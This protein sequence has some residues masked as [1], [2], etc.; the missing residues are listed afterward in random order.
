MLRS[1]KDLE[2]YTIA[3]TDG[4]VG[5]V[6][7]FLLDDER[8]TIRYL[9][10]ETGGFLDGR[11]VLVS[12][13]SLR[14]V[15][16]LNRR[17]HL[18]LTVDKIKNSPSVDT[19]KPVSR[20]HERDFYRYYG[21]PSYWEDLGLWG[22]GAYPSLLATGEYSET[23]VERPEDASADVHLRSAKE[24]RGYDIQGSDNAI[25]HFE[26]FIVEDD[27]W[28]LRYLVVDTRNWWFGKKVLVAPQWASTVSW[29]ER[30]IYVDVSRDFVK[31][32]PEWNTVAIDREYEARL[33]GYH[34]RAGYWSI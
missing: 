7:D 34:G 10:V 27:N 16:W 17:V 11:R 13:I 28:A 23:A 31:N 24:V 25:G 29:N 19:D 20:Q 2:G 30:K 15:D 3:A 22:I 14:T 18:A 4:D 8:W 32:S 1:L 6:V 21:Y 33:H 5:R 26:D 9:V 12:P